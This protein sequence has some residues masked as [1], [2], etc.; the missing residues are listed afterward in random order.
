MRAVEVPAPAVAKA[1]LGKL[2]LR[3]SQE[4]GG[5]ARCRTDVVAPRRRW[6]PNEVENLRL[7]F[8]R[9]VEADRG[10]VAFRAE[11]GEAG[12]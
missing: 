12:S 7:M 1:G 11:E 6:H 10:M 8:D 4:S 2:T 3:C 9:I 5:S